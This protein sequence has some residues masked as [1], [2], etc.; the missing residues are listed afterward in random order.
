MAIPSGAVNT[1][2]GGSGGGNGMRE[3]FKD[4]IATVAP[5]ETPFLSLIGTDTASNTFF[6]W[7]LDSLDTASTSNAVLEGDDFT[8]TSYTAPTRVANRCQISTKGIVVT[9]TFEAVRKAGRA[10]ELARLI[11]K[12]GKELRRDMEAIC[13][14]NQASTTGATDVARKTGTVC[15]WYGTTANASRGSGGSA[16]GY[17]NSDVAAATDSSTANMR[18]L[19]ESILKTTLAGC[20]DS[21]A[22]IKVLMCSSSQKQNIST[23]TGNATRTIDAEGNKLSTAIDVYESDFGTIR[24]VPNRLQRARDVHLLDPDMWRL[25]YLRPFQLQ[26]I[27]KAG[28][29]DKRSLVVEWGLMCMNEKGNGIIADV[30]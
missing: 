27:A 13:M 24:I 26:E 22:N 14:T 30:T 17:S 20:W 9:G 7:Q 25:A 11:I 3:D 16:G 23:F 1:Y 10:S 18:A 2:T 6:E 12:R 5:E 8:A 29:S 28:D 21:G 15:A 19:T 4:F